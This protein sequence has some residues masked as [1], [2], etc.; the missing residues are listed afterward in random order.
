VFRYRQD[1]SVVWADYSGGEILRGQL[2][3]ICDDEGRLDMRYQ[4]INARGELMTG[5]CKSMPE[6][7]PDGRVKLHEE[8]RWTSGD[9]SA[10]ESV[11]EEVGGESPGASMNSL[12]V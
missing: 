6:V 2:I 10:G 12:T 5:V 9:M 11:V 8:W 3:A 7:L 4:H 1:G